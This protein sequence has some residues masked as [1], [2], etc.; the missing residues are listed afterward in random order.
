MAKIKKLRRDLVSRLLI[1][2][3]ELDAENEKVCAAHLQLVIDTL[4]E[5]YPELE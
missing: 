4:S 3:D 1:I 5:R 2:R